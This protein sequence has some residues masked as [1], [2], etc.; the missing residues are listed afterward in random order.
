MWHRTCL[1]AAALVVALVRPGRAQPE[2]DAPPRGEISTQ[3]RIAA[4]AAAIVPGFVAH[5]LGSYVVHERRT[6]RRLLLAS[7]AGVGAAAIGGLPVGISGGNP[8][9]SPGIPLLIAGGG[10]FLVTWFADIGVAAGLDRE[11][12]AI[13]APPWSVE[14]GT[15][16]LH[17]AFR[18]R[19]L[20]HATGRIALGRIDL[21][22][23]TL[24]DAG[25]DARDG[26]LGAGVRILGAPATGHAIA[27]GS[28]LVVRSALRYHADDADM[29][30]VVTGDLVVAGRLDLGRYD[31]MLAGS[32]AELS[33][34]IGI[35]RARYA[36]DHD[37]DSLLLGGFAWGVYLGDRGEVAAYYDHRRDSLAGGIAAW[38]AAGFVGSVGV[39]GDVLI[40]P[41]WAVRGELEIGSSYV[42]TLALRYRGG[43]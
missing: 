38:R 11:G 28:R 43:S 10:T 25:G 17:D 1:T 13:A 7:G 19:A 5:G 12:R 20:V 14:L 35:E 16:W 34:G 26:E 23:G 31:A 40:T 32:F 3:R 8:Y 4:V 18:E 6:A 2:D 15:I 21:A 39:Y 37:T 9:A 33:T 24:V 22:A 42:T 29:V 41:R 30:T 36:G 27:D